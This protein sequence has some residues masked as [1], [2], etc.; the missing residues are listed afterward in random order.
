MH[1]LR[2]VFSTSESV[3]QILWWSY[4]NI[5]CIL[6]DN[7]S[8][9]IGFIDCRGYPEQFTDAGNDCIRCCV[10]HCS[11]DLQGDQS[12]AIL[13]HDGFQP[14]RMLI[15]SKPGKGKSADEIEVATLYLVPA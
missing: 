6:S 3:V 12:Q 8:C 1:A 7:D 14:S 15:A 9:I 5:I 2:M 13:R 10:V 4:R 11:S